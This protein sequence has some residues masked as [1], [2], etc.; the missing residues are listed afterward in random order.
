[1]VETDDRWVVVSGAG[2]AL[3]GAL[4]AHYGSLG[5]RILALDR[6]FGAAHR[7]A[8]NVTTAK[9]DLLAEEDIRRAFAEIADSKAGISL[10]INAVG[11]IWNEPVLAIRGNKFVTHDLASWRNVIEANLTAP[12]VVAKHV[13][14]HMARHGGGCIVNFS[15]IVS[16]GNAGQA[17]YSAAR[18]AS[19]ASRRTMAIELGPFGVRVNAVALGFID[20]AR[21]AKR[22]LKI[23]SSNIPSERR[24]ADLA[25]S[26]MSSA[27]SIF[28]LPTLSSMA[29]SCRW[30]EGCVSRMV[31]LW[32]TFAAH[33]CADPSAPAL[34]F[35]ERTSSF[36][37]LHALALSYAAALTAQGVGRG[38]VVGL[39][40]PKRRAAYGLLLACLRLGAPYVF[41]DPK[42]P[43]ERSA[44]IIDRVQPKILFTTGETP[45]R[46][47]Q[48]VSMPNGD[49]ASSFNLDVPPLH[50]G[51]TD[52]TGTDPA[53]I[54]FTSGSTGEPKG[55]VI[56]H[57]GVLSLME[58][59][60]DHHPY[61]RRRNASPTS[62]HCISIIQS[63]I[64]I[65]GCLT[66]RLLAHR[67][68]RDH[69]SS[70]LGQIHP[71]S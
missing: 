64:S 39:Q 1:M 42:A 52:V 35:S 51:V 40:L 69:Q 16:G 20:V 11:L 68:G 56:P 47:G 34:V 71:R 7:T 6:H 36:G 63:S 3:G 29:R 33:A 13:A 2:G 22:C 65:A 49:E 4:A 61:Q 44:R 43:P 25:G 54:M 59:A 10:L 38:D 41:L 60:R 8:V 57:Q 18:P 55:A 21:R 45:N 67:D 17:A 66:E 15:S 27:P 70:G 19:K 12:F 9:V 58:W 24:S 5:R 30:T 28:W 23:V 62:I 48:V 31:S 14:A 50:D 26:M 37:E 53:Y 46:H 32:N